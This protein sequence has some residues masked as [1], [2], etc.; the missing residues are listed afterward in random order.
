MLLSWPPILLWKLYADRSLGLRMEERPAD[1]VY[2]RD[3]T[4]V[5]A[6]GH[7]EDHLECIQRRYQIIS[8]VRID[9]T[10]NQT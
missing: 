2:R 8:L 10:G 1:V 3:F 5:G 9:L 6:S 7:G 4:V